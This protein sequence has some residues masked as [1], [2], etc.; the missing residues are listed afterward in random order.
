MVSSHHRKYTVHYGL[1]FPFW[2][3]LVEPN[4]SN[5]ESKFDSLWE[6]KKTRDLMNKMNTE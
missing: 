2:D 5:Y 3:R 6:E 4:D 1:D